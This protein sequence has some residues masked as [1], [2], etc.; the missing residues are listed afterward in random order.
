MKTPDG[1]MKASGFIL[2]VK[3]AAE[4]ALQQNP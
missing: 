2:K 4:E 1:V 3:G